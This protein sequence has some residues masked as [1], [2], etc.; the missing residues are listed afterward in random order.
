MSA[1]KNCAHKNFVVVD[2]QE[3][4]DV[5][6]EKITVQSKVKK[7]S[8]CD[9]E[10]FDMTLDTDRVFFICILRTCRQRQSEGE[11]CCKKEFGK[12]LG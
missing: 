6:G 5:K 11:Y 4:Y 10:I 7:C 1:V 12:T 2:K 9:Q 8:E 3:T